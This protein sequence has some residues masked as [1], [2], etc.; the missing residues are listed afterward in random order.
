[1]RQSGNYQAIRKP[2]GDHQEIIRELSGTQE[3][4]GLRNQV[5]CDAPQEEGRAAHSAALTAVHAQ[6]AESQATAQT[7]AEEA[8]SSSADCEQAAALI[9]TLEQ[10]AHTLKEQMGAF[11][12]AKN[13]QLT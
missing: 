6:L 11:L 5:S 12:T 4:S 2:S 8:S 13:K 10:Q 7:A 3:L 9:D 1:M